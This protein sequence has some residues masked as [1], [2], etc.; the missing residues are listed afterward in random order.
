[1][2][3]TR[4]VSLWVV[5]V[6]V[7]GGAGFIGSNLVDVLV[8]RGDE[9]V[10]VDD[11]SF[12]KRENLNSAAHHVARDIRDGVDLEAVELVFHLAAKTDVTS[13]VARPDEDAAVNVLGTVRVLEAARAVGAQ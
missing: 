6:A 12:G 5:K 13:S 7:T 8:A 9:V 3:A 10:V 4:L 2:P 11:L 1:M